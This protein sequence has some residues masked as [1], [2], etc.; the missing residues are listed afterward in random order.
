MGSIEIARR[1]IL[2]GIA[3]LIMV[4]ALVQLALGILAEA[5]LSYVGLGAQA[6]AISLGLMLKDAQTY[7]LLK[8]T[9]ALVPGITILLI[10][11][12]LNLAADGFR[13]QLGIRLRHP[14]VANGAA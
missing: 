9:L 12:A 7:A 4:Q 13:E 2:P 10:V 1:H 14:G 8:P 5:S 3:G 11:A 6:P